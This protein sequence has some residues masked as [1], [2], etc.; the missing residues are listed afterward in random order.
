MLSFSGK[1]AVITFPEMKGELVVAH[2]AILSVRQESWEGKEALLRL[3]FLEKGSF[4]IVYETRDGEEIGGIESML[5]FVGNALDELNDQIRS[6]APENS[7]LHLVPGG[8]EFP[9]IDPFRESFPVSLTELILAMP[10]DLKTNLSCVRNA[11]QKE[12]IEIKR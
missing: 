6:L 2:S 12:R 1:D 10:D 4:H 8:G 11:V 3:F 7:R 9:E 5:L